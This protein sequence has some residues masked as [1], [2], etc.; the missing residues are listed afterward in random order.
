MKKKRDYFFKR[1]T[2]EGAQRHFMDSVGFLDE[3]VATSSNSGFVK[4]ASDQNVIDR[5]DN[6][7][8]GVPR[9]VKPSQVPEVVLAAGV[10]HVAGT[11]VEV[12][13]LKLTPLTYDSK[14]TD[15]KIEILTGKPSSIMGSNEIDCIHVDSADDNGIFI[16]AN[17]TE[18]EQGTGNILQLKTG[19]IGMDKLAVLPTGGL[20]LV[21]GSGGVVEESAITTT[22]LAAIGSIGNSKI[23]VTGAGGLF[24][25]SG[26]AIAK[27]GYID[28]TPGTAEANKAV[29]LGATSKIDSLDITALKLNGTT[30]N[31]TAEELNVLN[32]VTAG[33]VTANKAVVVD[34][35]KKV[36]TLDL[37]EL[38]V[39][40]VA[41]EASISVLNSVKDKLEF[42]LNVSSDIQAQITA[43]DGRVGELE[44]PPIG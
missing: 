25:A 16:K 9:I 42:L 6:M 15:Y 38:K 13:G 8:D 20:V 33:I 21:S 36:D 30:L 10:S 29:V 28:V 35:S 14:R 26:V 39:G 43:I 27:L 40:G 11:A 32:G 44:E 2:Y 12:G 24:E 3:D 37:T 17:A 23:V 7:S 41:L 31:S 19:G 34:A 4:V 18:F 5:N 22:Q 1:K